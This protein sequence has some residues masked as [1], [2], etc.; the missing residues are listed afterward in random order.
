MP[1]FYRLLGIHIHVIVTGRTRRETCGSICKAL[2]GGVVGNEHGSHIGKQVCIW[3]DKEILGQAW[4]DD[5]RA[6]SNRARQRVNPGNTG[7]YQNTGEQARQGKARQG[8]ARQGK[9]RQGKAR[10]GKARQGKA[11]L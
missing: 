8:K 1:G 2:L 5:R 9:A 11:R 4:V 10:Q 7:R 6:I 3:Q